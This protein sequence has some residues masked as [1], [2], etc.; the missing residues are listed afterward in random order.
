MLRKSE[1]VKKEL[2]QTVP[3]QKSFPP[4]RIRSNEVKLSNDSYL[5]AVKQ[6][7]FA[8]KNVPRS[9]GNLIEGIPNEKNISPIREVIVQLSIRL[10]SQPQN[11]SMS[12]MIFP[13]KKT[14]DPKFQ[15]TPKSRQCQRAL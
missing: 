11:C 10:Q 2:L 6:V 3:N 7:L 14:F 15:A 9:M 5:L 8:N 12:E 1:H 4:I 13:V